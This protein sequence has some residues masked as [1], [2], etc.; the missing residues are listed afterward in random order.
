MGSIG[1]GRETIRTWGTNYEG[2]R[3]HRI[4]IWHNKRELY[5][6]KYGDREIG[7]FGIIEYGNEGER[8]G[9][10]NATYHCRQ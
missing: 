8:N 3:E 2:Q 9:D 5:N 10:T 4:Q 6:V 1:M 7:N